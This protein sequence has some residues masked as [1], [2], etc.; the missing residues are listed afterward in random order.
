MNLKCEYCGKKAGSKSGLTLHMKS[1]KGNTNN[2]VKEEKVV[3]T[4]KIQKKDE[5][6]EINEPMMEIQSSD[7]LTSG[8]PLNSVI[9]LDGDV[10]W[11]NPGNYEWVRTKT[12]KLKVTVLGKEKNNQNVIML[13]LKANG[14]TALWSVAEHEVL[15]GTYKVIKLGQEAEEN[16]VSYEDREVEKS[17][18]RENFRRAVISFDESNEDKKKYDKIHKNNDKIQRPVILNYLEKYGEESAPGKL[19]KLVVDFGFSIQNVRTPGKE[20]TTYDS[21]AILQWLEENGHEDCIKKSFD[22]N[23]W[24]NL[25]LAG[26]V[27]SEV[28]REVEKPGVTD[29]TFSLCIL[30][31]KNS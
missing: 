3:K 6:T 19:D 20:Y 11:Q 28:L 9:M 8:I 5:P 21:D 15:D 24:N 23:M 12:D 1:C 25:K 27:P 13:M 17:N 4:K 30:R 18:D 2:N 22:P 31:D 29:D 16:S 26:K 10:W 7:V 14:G